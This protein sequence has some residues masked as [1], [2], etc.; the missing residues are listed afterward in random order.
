MSKRDIFKQDL[1]SAGE[2]FADAFS[3][4]KD[5]I[6]NATLIHI[7]GKSEII[8]ENFKGILSYSCSEIIIK[9]FGMKYSIKGCNMVIAYY[10]DEDMKILGEIKEVKVII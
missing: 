10:S 3:L 8:I 1:I 7:V 4:P 9:G 2:K 5:M 6:V